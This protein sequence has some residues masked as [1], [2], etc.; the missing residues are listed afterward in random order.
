[1]SEL[2]RQAAECRTTQASGNGNPR[3][4]SGELINAL[5]RVP[6]PRV[7]RGGTAAPS[8]QI[9]A[10]LDLAKADQRRLRDLVRRN[11]TRPHLLAASGS[12]RHARSAQPA[13]GTMVAN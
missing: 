7:T 3:H 11:R 6:R 2:R 4:W 13:P 10:R 12:V 8:G 5:A 9:L 1:M